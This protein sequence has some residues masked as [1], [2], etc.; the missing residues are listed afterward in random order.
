MSDQT[1][2][3]RVRDIEEHLGMLDQE[4]QSVP[5]FI[6]ARLRVS[7]SRVARLA[8]D[9]AALRRDVAAVAAKLDRLAAGIAAAPLPPA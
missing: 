6:D 3:Q 1:L 2:E 5:D 4:W 7:D 9:I 8:V